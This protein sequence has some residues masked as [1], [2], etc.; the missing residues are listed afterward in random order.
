MKIKQV[1]VHYSNGTKQ[2]EYLRNGKPVYKTAQAQT[3]QDRSILNLSRLY[4]ALEG[5]R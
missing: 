1:T 4:M 2:V 5:A 3:L